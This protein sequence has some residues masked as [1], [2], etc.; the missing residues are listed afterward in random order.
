MK[1]SQTPFPAQPPHQI[2]YKKWHVPFEPEHQALT[3]YPMCLHK[4]SRHRSPQ[5]TRN[6]SC[7]YFH[8]STNVCQYVSFSLLYM[9]VQ[10]QKLC[11][12]EAS[13]HTC[14]SSSSLRHGKHHS[15][16]LK[17][18]TKYY[19]FPLSQLQNTGKTKI[20]PSS[21]GEIC[22]KL[23]TN[24]ASVPTQLWCGIQSP[25]LMFLRGDRFIVFART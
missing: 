24:S 22:Y 15:Q 2:K 20:L 4:S 8:P 17:F 12:Q 16:Q 1:C 6:I 18:I 23:I 5:F 21:N 13:F 3:S 11:R 9:L 14:L 25:P 10:D 7:V 19:S